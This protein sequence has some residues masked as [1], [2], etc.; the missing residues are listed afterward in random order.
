[1]PLPAFRRCMPLVT[2]L[3]SRTAARMPLGT[4]LQSRAAASN[5]A[6]TS[7][8]R[9]HNHSFEEDTLPELE[10]WSHPRLG[11]RGWRTRMALA[12]AP[13]NGT[14]GALKHDPWGLILEGRLCK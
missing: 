2:P 5:G 11:G 9:K 4:P 14:L 8:F 7:T 3:Q 1:M 10:V 6:V 12:T 13:K